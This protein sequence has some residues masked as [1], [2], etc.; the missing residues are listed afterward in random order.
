MLVAEDL[1]AFFTE[2]GFQVCGIA[3]SG[4]ECFELLN[5]TKPDI[6][7]LDINLKGK[8][9]G[10][11]IAGIVSKHYN[12]P[13]IYLSAIAE[14]ETVKR[15]LPT[16]PSA[17]LSKP[18]NK[19]D[20]KV[21]VELACQKS[22]QIVLN[23]SSNGSISDYRYLFLKV[24]NNYRRIDIHSI[25]YLEAKGSY[26]LIVTPEKTYTLSYNLN[27]FAIKIKDPLFKRVHRSFVINITKVE[28]FD[29]NSI[30]INK[31]AIPVSKQHQKE[32]RELFLKL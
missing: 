2:C 7:I 31:R 20:L 22:N 28:G 21:A 17:Y 32:V 6:M 5:T 19:N 14:S 16:N 23:Q 24:G 3:G 30:T 26:S 29:R 11:E 8:Q 27:H 13:F 10:I 15:A 25:L 9:D 4:K 18:F 12:L 1:A